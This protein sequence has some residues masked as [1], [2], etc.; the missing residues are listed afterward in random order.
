MKQQTEPPIT[1]ILF[2]W[3]HTLAYTAIGDNSFAT[4]QAALFEIAGMAYSQAEI[5][6]ALAK[7]P[8][9]AEQPQTRRDIGQQYAYLLKEL[10]YEDRSWP[11]LIR[12]YQT[13]ALLPTFLFDD[14][15]PTL[16]RLR[17]AGYRL[18]ILSNHSR[19]ARPVMEKLV[20]DLISAEFI[21]ISEEEGV[22]KPAA[23]LFRRAATRLRT[24]AAQCALVGDN[25]RVDAL[26]SVQNGGFGRG[27]WLNRKG[28]D[29]GRDLPPNVTHITTLNALADAL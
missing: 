25:L 10:G 16:E 20:G 19:S 27:V 6:A 29:L 9:P 11:T 4:R 21:V 12:L 3:D 23:S 5:E 18:G 26:G 22:H 7:V 13:Y 28:S 2:D 15:R 17:G 24:P 14:A 8:R 1:T